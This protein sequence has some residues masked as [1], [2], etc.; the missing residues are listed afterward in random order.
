MAHDL[1]NVGRR[2]PATT[3]GHED[4]TVDLVVESLQSPQCKGT[5]EAGGGVGDT[6]IDE[7][8]FC[9]D[10]ALD[11]GGRRDSAEDEAALFGGCQTDAE[12]KKAH[13]I[14]VIHCG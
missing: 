12:Q 13:S 8:D 1:R 5:D 3:G 11:L 6:D 14:A 10:K 2:I 9:L 4:I 7:L